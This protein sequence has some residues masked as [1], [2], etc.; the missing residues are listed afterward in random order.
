MS[1]PVYTLQQA[2]EKAR[3]FCAYQE[4]CQQEVRDKLYDLGMHREEVEQG[5]S[6]LITEGFL[7]EE[8]FARSYARGKFRI[9]HWGRTKIRYALKQK[10]ISDYCIRKAM[11]EIDGD[12]YIEVLK[13]IAEKK[14]ASIK[15]KNSFSH[16]QKIVQYLL[17]RGFELDIIQ[18]VLSEES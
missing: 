1:A 3:H 13:Q 17:Q 16:R 10:K 5:I 6:D 4:R 9:K 18:S 2:L 8:R 15:E 12:E 14:S 11:E 7:D